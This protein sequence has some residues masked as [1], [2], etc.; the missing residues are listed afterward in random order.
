[1]E[2]KE[3]AMKYTIKNHKMNGIVTNHPNDLISLMKSFSTETV[4]KTEIIPEI[5]E[6]KN[7]YKNVYECFRYTI[8]NKQLFPK[9]ENK[10]IL[11]ALRIVGLKEDI[12]SLGLMD[13]SSSEKKQLQIALAL[14][15]NP[16]TIILVEPFK[17]M[18]FQ[19]E[20]LMTFLFQKIV[21]KF[22][23]TI[24]IITEDLES[25]LKNDNHIIIFKND[26]FIIEGTKE[27]IIK[28]IE[29]LRKHKV[30]LPEIIE[31]IYLAKKRK[32]VRI[33]YSYDVRDLIKDI[34]KHV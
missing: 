2:I 7:S 18:D 26:K 23:K 31:F 1:M 5:M 29:L 17:S 4:E 34:Y 16:D 27:E 11:D 3:N 19:N 20:K 8:Y 24:I 32:N 22:K 15:S 12:L 25:V 6:I 28:N 9:D 10:K 21:E 30:I 13:I 33:D 14:L